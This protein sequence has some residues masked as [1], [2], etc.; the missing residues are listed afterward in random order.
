M[1]AC[2]TAD[3]ES[4]WPRPRGRSGCVR[5]A[6]TS[7]SRWA[8]RCRR[9]GTAKAGVPQNTMRM[10]FTRKRS[11]RTAFRALPLALFLHLLDLAFDEI[12]LEHAEMLKVEDAVEVIDLVVKGTREIVFGF[13]FEPFTSRILGFYRDEL[14]ADDVAAKAWDGEA[15][16]FFTLFPLG[17][18]DFGVYENDF[19]F[20]VFAGGDINHRD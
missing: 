6:R 9:E 7:K 11:R 4:S 13:H 5:T 12:A 10:V 14:R 1:A 16:L 3:W 15:A 19:G 8:R 17:V 20:G 18:N 2:F